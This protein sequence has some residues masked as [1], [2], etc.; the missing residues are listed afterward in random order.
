M[1]FFPG[2]GRRDAWGGGGGGNAVDFR[3]LAPWSGA[4]P[5]KKISTFVPIFL[6]RSHIFDYAIKH[7]FECKE[8]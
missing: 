3:I 7:H 2:K 4:S 8:I 1:G 5:S 6:A